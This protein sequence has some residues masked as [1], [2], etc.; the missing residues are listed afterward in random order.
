MKTEDEI[1]FKNKA[2]TI[3]EAIGNKK[4]FSDDECDQ[5]NAFFGHH[6]ESELAEFL[7]IFRTLGFV[8]GKHNK[9]HSKDYSSNGKITTFYDKRLIRIVSY[10]DKPPFTDLGNNQATLQL[11]KIK[12]NHHK[13]MKAFSK[14][15]YALLPERELKNFKE[16]RKWLFEKEYPSKKYP[17]NSFGM[18]SI[19]SK[20][21]NTNNTIKAVLLKRKRHITDDRYPYMLIGLSFSQYAFFVPV[22]FS[23]YDNKTRKH[24]FLSA[25]DI[26]CGSINTQSFQVHSFSDTSK[27]ITMDFNVNM[28]YQQSEPK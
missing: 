11:N 1:S 12:I 26:C 8:Q 23:K 21:A 7:S 17:V 10:S 16:T 9:P 20:T 24:I 14:I 18:V 4:L 28:T 27:T 13:I 3:P 19:F 2:H 5:C 15:A 25:S 22:Q 6:I